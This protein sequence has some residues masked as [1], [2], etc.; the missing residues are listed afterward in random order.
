MKPTGENRITRRRPC[1]TATF[2]TTHPPLIRLSCVH[3]R[4]VH[5]TSGTN[6]SRPQ[7]RY[8]VGFNPS[9]GNQAYMPKPNTLWPT[10]YE[11]ELKRFEHTSIKCDETT[12]HFILL[13]SHDKC[14]LTC[15]LTP[16][17]RIILGFHVRTKCTNNQKLY[18]LFYVLLTTH[19]DICV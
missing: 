11:A 10:K 17:S 19:L 3:I 16:L 12:R 13:H 15:V 8:D 4:T 14:I 2:S 5:V 9:L 6:I 1:P 7:P 18:G